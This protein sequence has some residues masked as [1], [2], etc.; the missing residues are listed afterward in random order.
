M[1]EE[2]RYLAEAMP[3]SR[4]LLLSPNPLPRKGLLKIKTSGMYVRHDSHSTEFVKAI[5][6]NQTFLS[7]RGFLGALRRQ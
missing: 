5:A 7:G 1:A 3:A 4:R 2:M 6:W